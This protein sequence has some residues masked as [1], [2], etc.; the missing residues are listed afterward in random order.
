MRLPARRISASQI[1]VSTASRWQKKQPPLFILARPVVQQFPRHVRYVPIIRFLP[2][3]DIAAQV[4]HQRQ[5]IPLLLLNT[6]HL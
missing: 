3:S 6:V 2:P 4:I 5:V 1:I